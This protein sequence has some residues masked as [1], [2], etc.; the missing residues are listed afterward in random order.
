MRT[1]TNFGAEA[2]LPNGVAHPPG[3]TSLG[4]G[5]IVR[6]PAGQKKP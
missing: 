4:R 5:S 2:G 6:A 3:G 1:W